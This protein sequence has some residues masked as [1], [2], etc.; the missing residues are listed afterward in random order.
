MCLRELGFYAIC[1]QSEHCLIS[2]DQ[3]KEFKERFKHVIFFMDNDKAGLDAN[4][5]LAITH[6]TVSIAIPPEKYKT[7]DIS[8][9]I[10][11][12]GSIAAYKLMKKLTSR[13]ITFFNKLID[14]PYV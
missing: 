6:N 3:M 5:K 2:K 7:T 12:F 14:I 8:D 11:K 13:S 1:G 4:R 10:L 9:F